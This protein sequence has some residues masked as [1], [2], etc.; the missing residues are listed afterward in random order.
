MG[1]V[2]SVRV[3]EEADLQANPSL[4]NPHA[5]TNEYPISTPVSGALQVAAGSN[6]T[7]W[8]TEGIPPH[9]QLA[10]LRPFDAD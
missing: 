7:L 8:V 10:R 6:R 2:N 3:V 5:L 1:C 4:R 9:N